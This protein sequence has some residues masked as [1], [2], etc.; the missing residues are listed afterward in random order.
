MKEKDYKR[1][2][3]LELLFDLETMELTERQ[4]T[5]LEGAELKD[6]QD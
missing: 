2:V 1:A 3:R 6:G 5:E 4:E